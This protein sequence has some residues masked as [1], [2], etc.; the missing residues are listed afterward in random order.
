MFQYAFGQYLQLK[1]DVDVKYD[2]NDFKTYFREY[3]LDKIFNVNPIYATD[4]EISKLRDFNPKKYL[5]LKFLPRFIRKNFETYKNEE[6]IPFDPNVLNY[7]NNKY[8]NG[9]WQSENY[10]KDIENTL[11]REFTFK[12]D[13]DEKNKIIA[14]EI[15][16]K[17]A[18]SLH[19]RRGDYLTN[20]PLL[21]ICSLDYYKQ[22]IN[23]ISKNVDNPYFYIFSDDPA[24]TED[25][26]K[27]SWPYSIVNLNTKTNQHMDMLLMS[28]C[29]HNVIANSSFSWWGAWLNSNSDKI[30]IA[31]KN[32]T[33][34]EMYSPH[35]TP[36]NW[37]RI[38]NEWVKNPQFS[39]V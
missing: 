5:H 24:W 38:H 28:Y 26:L 29:K 32:W 22:A 2:I 12:N 23:H 21:E 4:E 7:K 20:T 1:H 27:L 18:V 9:Y 37:I 16:S 3:I 11:K 33:S 6:K 25:N 13:I 39:L 10:F 36:S 8:L 17:N 19:I 15:I 30:V 35:R 14:D 34:S 31:P